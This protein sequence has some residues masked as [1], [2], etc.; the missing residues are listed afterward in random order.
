MFNP[1]NPKMC[2]CDCGFL[3]YTVTLTPLNVPNYSRDFHGYLLKFQCFGSGARAVVTG[4]GGSEEDRGPITGVALRDGG[5]GYAVLGREEPE[6]LIHSTGGLPEGVQLVPSF[7]QTQDSC[8]RIAWRISGVTF[9]GSPPVA[10]GSQISFA[11]LPATAADKIA[12]AQ[13]I[14]AS[15]RHEEPTL[16]ASISSSAGVAELPE[17]EVVY[18]QTTY[19]GK[20]AWAVQ[21]IL[22]LSGGS[23]YGGSSAIAVLLS[24][25]DGDQKV[26]FGAA[27]ATGTIQGDE[28]VSVSVS[29]TALYA[30][31]V[32]DSISVSSGGVYYRESRD[33]PP[34]V[35]EVP[36]ENTAHENSLATKPVVKGIVDDDIE[37]DT[38]G[39]VIDLEIEDPGD[40]FLAWTDSEGHYCNYLAQE[41]S[42]TPFVLK[43][44]T[45]MP[46]V[47]ICVSAT[48]GSN[49]PVDA[50]PIAAVPEVTIGNPKWDGQ[51]TGILEEWLELKNAAGLYGGGFNLALLG[52]KEP[53]V[54]IREG[55]LTGSGLAVSFQLEEIQNSQGLPVWEIANATVS[56]GG[57]GYRYGD[58]AEVYADLPG[59]TVSGRAGSVIVKTVRAEPSLSVLI[60]SL[61]GGSGAQFSV[62][63]YQTSNSPA[64]WGVESVT[65]LSGGE[66]YSPD[67]SFAYINYSFPNIPVVFN[68]LASITAQVEDGQ[69][70]SISVL[71]PGQYY[72]ET[73]VVDEIEVV[74][75]GEFYESDVTLPTIVA[76][77]Q[78]TVVQREP[79]QGSGAE[80]SVI[81]DDDP[82][83]LDFGRAT[84]L[85]VTSEGSGYRLVMPSSGGPGSPI[86]GTGGPSPP[87]PYHEGYES[88]M[89]NYSC[90]YITGCGYNNFDVVG[91]NGIILVMSKSTIKI[92]QYPRISPLNPLFNTGGSLF[93]MP[94]TVLDAD[95]CAS[96]EGILEPV[97]P[98]TPPEMQIAIQSGGNWLSHR[99]DCC[100][101]CYP[102]S[103]ELP[104]VSEIVVTVNIE[105]SGPSPE[106]QETVLTLTAESWSAQETWQSQNRST[107]VRA[108]MG[109]SGIFGLALTI[110]PTPGFSFNELTRRKIL[111]GVNFS[112]GCYP[113]GYE[114]WLWQQAEGGEQ[115]Q[116]F[117][118]GNELPEFQ[119][120]GYDI[121]SVSSSA[122]VVYQ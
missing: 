35:A 55:D 111:K 96:F 95:G 48:F 112:G 77:V 45:P 3:P 79:S 75:A 8:G 16:T 93:S 80:I 70:V 51:P 102:G 101:G 17:F 15:T 71:N 5:C 100:Y 22:V 76:D 43:A 63:V 9:T 60:S 87:Y 62:N 116:D 50:S 58:D 11:Q 13:S 47:S 39:Q 6:I 117:F 30:K 89:K 25:G 122:T 21:E 86:T 54:S 109:S 72:R 118:P 10:S 119:W 20:E 69:I 64:T 91:W 65:V 68:T 2:G 38:F 42:D 83:S 37:S 66:G 105:Y 85:T 59:S 113:E 29:G 110:N 78:A 27:V 56:S 53:T 88:N 99:G 24:L 98:E 33:I 32:L 97:V 94:A 82:N 26:N 115:Y 52:R 67:S 92:T 57:S 120:Q 121:A 23:G 41:I 7:E 90:S 19:A 81:I 74:D 28:I 34:I 12:S 108:D 36:L 44:A 114:Q 73:G 4:P 106:S 31:R 46:L 104:L 49:P 107:F 1:D 103:G 14:S 40:G 84:G 61:S 18:Q